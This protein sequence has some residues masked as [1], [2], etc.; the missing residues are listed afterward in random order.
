MKIYRWD[1]ELLQQYSHGDLIALAESADAARAMLRDELPSWIKEN[2]AQE[3]Y[4]AFEPWGDMESDRDGYE[5]LVA[6][7]EKDI[8]KEPTEHSTLWMNG[9]E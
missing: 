5:K 3:W 4:E 7:F 6:L 2:R 9:S 8:A 1:S